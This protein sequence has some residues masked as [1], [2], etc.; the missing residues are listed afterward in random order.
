MVG[1][2]L[3]GSKITEKKEKKL[4]KNMIWDMEEDMEL[5]SSVVSGRFIG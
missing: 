4:F 2:R 1:Y 3:L 5:I